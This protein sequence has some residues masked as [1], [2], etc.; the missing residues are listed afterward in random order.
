MPREAWPGDEA[1]QLLEQAL[2]QQPSARSCN[3]P[4]TADSEQRADD[5]GAQELTSHA[6]LHPQNTE[7]LLRLQALLRQRQDWSSLI[8]LLPALRKCNQISAKQ[9]HNIEYQAWSGRL[10]AASQSDTQDVEQALK[11]LDTAWQGL[12]DRLK[13]NQQLVAAYATELLRLEAHE[14][15]E[16]LLRRAL[17]NGLNDELIDPMVA[18]KQKM[19]PPVTVSRK[20]AS[21]RPDNPT[22]LRA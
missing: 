3:C 12:S 20:L 5:L 7:V 19:Q 16:S 14:Q 11:S 22:L 10:A 6:E 9:L 18:P 17:R 2:S 15:A 1:D 21:A 8:G 13:N 4:S